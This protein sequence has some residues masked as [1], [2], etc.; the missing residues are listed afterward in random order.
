MFLRRRVRKT[1][2]DLHCP[3]FVLEVMVKFTRL[4][5]G[6]LYLFEVCM[7]LFESISGV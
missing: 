1:L 6:H 2:N 4:A 7:H 5:M 3:Y